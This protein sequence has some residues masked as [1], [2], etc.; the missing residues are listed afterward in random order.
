MLSTNRKND[1]NNFLKIQNLKIADLAL[2]NTAFTHSSYLKEKSL[3]DEEDNERLEFFGDAILKLYV[4]EYLMDKYK[5]YSEGQLSKLR[6]YVVSE[7]VLAVIAN[8]INLKKYLL[9]GKNEKKTLPI[10]IL[11]DALEALIAVIYYESSP[12]KAKD[13]IFTHWREYIQAADKNEEKDNFKAVLQEFTQGNNLGLPVYETLRESG[14]DHDKEFEV[15]VF[16]D[17]NEYARG[18]GKTKKDASQHA[19]KNALIKLRKY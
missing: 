6:A 9:V 8:K 5:K 10:S 2:L 15:A 16:L 3:K 1:L 14:P 13:Y 11:A 4:S 18:L 17:N 19:A 12:N 7:K